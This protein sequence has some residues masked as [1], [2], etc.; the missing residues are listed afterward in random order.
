MSSMSDEDD[1][2]E[3]MDAESNA[4]GISTRSQSQQPLIGGLDS[5]GP[6]TILR[7]KIINAVGQLSAINAASGDVFQQY[8]QLT[9]E[10]EAGTIQLQ[11]ILTT[12]FKNKNAERDG[13][14]FKLQDRIQKLQL[15]K[16]NFLNGLKAGFAPYELQIQQL[17]QQINESLQQLARQQEMNVALAQTNT[18]L[19]AQL[20][21]GLQQYQT[22]QLENSR[23]SEI[24]SQQT[25]AFEAAQTEFQNM[26]SRK[27]D[28]LNQLKEIAKKLDIENPA[29]VI[30]QIEEDKL[31][32]SSLQDSISREDEDID[33]TSYRRYNT[34]RLSIK[35]R[36]EKFKKQQDENR[37]EIAKL[38]EKAAEVDRLNVDIFH[39]SQTLANK[40]QQLEAKLKGS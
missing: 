1:R 8:D 38:T 35:N 31:N 28:L 12:D 11:S 3:S 21:S 34:L 2:A 26:E 27:N 23:I 7:D 30:L 36:F 6:I 29:D 39:M 40:E 25:T 13:A 32:L 37:Q 19:E 14:V 17:R 20:V 18:G 33:V 5:R 10:L 24:N 15:K 16:T 9:Q 22:V 4:Y